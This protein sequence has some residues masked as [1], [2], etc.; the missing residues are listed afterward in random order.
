MTDL[1]SKG[2]SHFS[3]VSWISFSFSCNTQKKNVYNFSLI[4]SVFLFGFRIRRKHCFKCQMLI[5][6]NFTGNHGIVE[7]TVIN[8]LT[9]WRMHTRKLA[10]LFSFGSLERPKWYTFIEIIIRVGY[11]TGGNNSDTAIAFFNFDFHLLIKILSW[12]LL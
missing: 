11:W 8:N 10:T 5:K 7:S 12:L 6:N 2:L 4:L 1:V 3:S 9:E